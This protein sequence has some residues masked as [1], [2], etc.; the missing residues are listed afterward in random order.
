MDRAGQTAQCPNS[1]C[2]AKLKLPTLEQ[3]EAK[4]KKKALKKESSSQPPV[5]PS[6]QTP[7]A[8]KQSTKP[9]RTKRPA[10]ELAPLPKT[11]REL[12]SGKQSATKTKGQ[13]KSARKLWPIA[14]GIAGVVVLAFAVSSFLPSG[15]TGDVSPGSTRIF[16]EQQNEFSTKVIPFLEKYCID[17]HSSDF[18]EGGVKFDQLDPNT[19][20]LENHE[21]WHHAY[22]QISLGAMPPSDAEAPPLAEREAVAKW[23]D[24]AVNHFDC[25]GINNPGHVTV[26]RLNRSEY[27]NT[28]RDLLGVNLELSKNF[29]TDDVGYGFDNIGDVLTISPI[30]M[31]RYLSAAETATSAA[32]ALPESFV[33]DRKWTGN[34]FV[35]SGSGSANSNEVGF[36]SRGSAKA[37]FK[38]TA[39]GKYEFRVVV[40]ATQAGDELAKCKISLDNSQIESHEIPEHRKYK[41]IA[42]SQDVKKGDH[43]LDVAFENDFYDPDAEDPKRRDRNMYL[44]YVEIIGPEKV[45][46]SAYPASHRMIVTATP[47]DKL[48]PPQ[49]A[50][51][52]L[53]KFTDR[54]FRRP[55]TDQELTRYLKIFELAQSRNE[56][57]ERSLQIAIQAVLV[58]P[59]FL[60]RIENKPDSSNTEAVAVENFALASRISYFLWSSMPDEE[61][62]ELAKSG[63]LNQDEVLTKQVKRMLLDPKAKALTENFVGQWL[64]LRQLNEIS[65]DPDLFPEFNKELVRDMQQ[66]TE[67]L[68]ANILERDLSLTELLTAD[69]TFVNEKLAKLYGI[70]SVKGSK[71]QQVS[72][73]EKPRRGLISHAGI[74]TLTSFP[75]R[76]SPVKRGEWVLENILAQDPPPAPPSVP[77]LEETQA[78]NPNLSFREQLVLHQKDPICSSCHK[79]MDG[80]GF[81]L[82]NYDAI[83]RWREKEGGHPIDS[84]GDLPDGKSFNG[85]LELISILGQRPDEFTRCLSE[86]M[87]T[88]ALGRGLQWYDRCTI[89]DIIMATRDDEY[90]ISRLIVEIVK[91]PAFRKQ[92]VSH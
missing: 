24:G 53:R 81:G 28:I 90:R 48:A 39:G 26:H 75:N 23:L 43:E 68:F 52:V 4:L 51:Q 86:K 87:L 20:L 71:F 37:R 55:V 46:D 32:I 84:R 74:L 36:P 44:K 27:D 78:S 88:Y 47:S 50:T 59:E 2:G 67:L 76:T 15:S 18:S 19:N 56:T 83:G 38:A 65:P 12:R 42:W 21:F 66:E 31:E 9:V 69:Y 72:L 63:K 89:D 73:K 8:K 85:P 60:F 7:V 77:S 80:I 34:D 79:L 6:K 70:D 61:L 11:R 5:K 64:G 17:C 3:I 13:K 10:P 35:I 33:V 30:L 92:Q 45:P 29:P 54:A 49:A 1:D 41:T 62:F 57:Y 58:S 22:L 82:Q 40:A 16:A 91:S 14:V 25:Q